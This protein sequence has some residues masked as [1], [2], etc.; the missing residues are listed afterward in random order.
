MARSLVA[1]PQLGQA[2]TTATCPHMGTTPRPHQHPR[3]GVSQ[4]NTLLVCFQQGQG[5]E[6]LSLAPPGEVL[7]WAQLSLGHGS[8]TAGGRACQG[9]VPHPTDP[10]RA[11]IT[12]KLRGTSLAG[13]WRHLEAS[14]QQQPQLEMLM[15][16]PHWQKVENHHWE[17]KGKEEEQVRGCCS[18]HRAGHHGQGMGTRGGKMKGRAA[19]VWCKLIC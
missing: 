7:S 6:Q 19:P 14:G 2:G 11:R 16:L 15:L 18:D 5:R 3:T 17:R 12:A 10:W 13:A 9:W 1:H 8:A 4:G